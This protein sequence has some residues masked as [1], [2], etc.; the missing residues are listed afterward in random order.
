MT[1]QVKSRGP[2][3]QPRR[4][5]KRI[6]SARVMPLKHL[7]WAEGRNPARHWL[8][9]TVTRTRSWEIGQ[10]QPILS[11]PRGI[12]AIVRSIP[13][14]LQR[15]TR[16]MEWTWSKPSWIS[17][18]SWTHSTKSSSTRLEI[19]SYQLLKSHLSLI[20]ASTVSWMM[21]NSHYLS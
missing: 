21:S 19:G 8:R 16:R 20:R 5:W 12:R 1:H 18:K 10:S 6:S 7:W 15:V 13:R 2:L 14:S 11:T 17:W 3:S 4:S 9:D